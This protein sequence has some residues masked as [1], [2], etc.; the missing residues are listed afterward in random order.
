MSDGKIVGHVQAIFRYPVKSMRGEHLDV[1][2]MGLHG[3]DGDRRFALRKL[4]DASGFPWLTA[5]KLPEL[6]LFSPQR[7][8][9]APENPPTHVRTPDGIVMEI[10][11]DDLAAEVGRR[12]GAPVQMMHLRHGIFDDASV[13]VIATETMREVGRLTGMNL[14]IR[15][16]RPNIVVHTESGEPFQEDRWVGGSLRFGAGADSS[17]VAVTERDT[18]C[19]MIGLDPDSAQASPEILKEVVRSHQNTAGVYA[20]VTRPGR[21]VVGQPVHFI[22]FEAIQ[23]EV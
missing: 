18:R 19:S 3:I 23:A 20:T 9:G 7:T 15:R 8:A 2:S 12:H 17:V 14:D 1:A 11:G 22:P 21:L 4:N 13:S 6:I 5:T 16:F 10:F